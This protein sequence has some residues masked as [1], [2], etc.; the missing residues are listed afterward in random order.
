MFYTFLMI[1]NLNMAR[2]PLYNDHL[3][4]CDVFQLMLGWVLSPYIKIFDMICHILFKSIVISIVFFVM[5]IILA[6]LFP[7]Q[8][9]EEE[10]TF[11][12]TRNGKEILWE[13]SGLSKKKI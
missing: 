6:A 3:R 7:E 2:I 8:S 5:V 11:V 13:N 4:V 9:K 10:D 1:I 12:I